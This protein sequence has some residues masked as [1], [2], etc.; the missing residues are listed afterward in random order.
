MAKNCGSMQVIAIIPA[1]N[2]AERVGAVLETVL[3][4]PVVNKIIVVDDGSSD[5]T[6]DVARRY[7]N[8][9]VERLE[10][11]IGKGG[12]MLRGATIASGADVL[13]F[14]DAD[15]I[16]LKP[17]HICALVEPVLRGDADMALG[18]FVGGRGATDL[19]QHLAP[20]ITGQRA[21]RRALFMTIPD[22]DRVGFG[23]ELAITLHVKA[24]HRPV[25]TA[26]LAGVTH[27]MK[28]E[29]LGF[30]RGVWAR[31]KMYWEMGRFVAAYFCTGR[32]RQACRAVENLDYTA[33]SEE[34]VRRP[35]TWG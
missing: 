1:H 7:E 10:R 18:K 25:A 29:K 15:L 12:A 27:P 2:E 34:P 20:V 31:G 33:A 11:N 8:V 4:T 21:I 19:A 3:A 13:L 14:L 17:G 5:G 35:T 30:R 32:A 26:A 6:A 23:I 9:R 28:E 16:G 22:L 24:A